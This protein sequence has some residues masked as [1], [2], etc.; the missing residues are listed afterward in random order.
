MRISFPFI[1]FLVLFTI[2][3]FGVYNNPKI[4]RSPLIGKQIP[5]FNLEELS[6]GKIINQEFFYDKASVLNVWASWC[7][8]CLREHRYIA[9]LKER[10][11]INV[12]GL[13]YKDLRDDANG[14]LDIHG[15]PY[16]IILYD[17]FGNYAMNLGVYGVPETF[18]IDKNGIIRKKF[19][20]A[21]SEQVYYEELLPMIEKIN[22][23]N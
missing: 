22:E 2:L 23:E 10:E 8:E 4:V 1:I 5:S 19:I 20:G 6:S 13:N 3:I 16:E 18:L 21:L 9:D 11:I 14:W 15:N 7:L 12:F 17:N